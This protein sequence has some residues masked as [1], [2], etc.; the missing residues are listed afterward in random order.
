[1]DLGYNNPTKSGLPGGVGVG[2]G[3]DRRR[4]DVLLGTGN[5][6]YNIFNHYMIA[7]VYK[8]IHIKTTKNGLP[9]Y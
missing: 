1:M 8:G 9:T 4:T 7:S 3:A 2:T 5:I 6:C